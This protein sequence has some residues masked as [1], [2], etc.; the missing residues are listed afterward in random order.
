MIIETDPFMFDLLHMKKSIYFVL[1]QYLHRIII[2]KSDQ[3]EEILV[4]SEYPTSFYWTCYLK[5]DERK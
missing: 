2:V 5:T 3:E 4:L 1:Y